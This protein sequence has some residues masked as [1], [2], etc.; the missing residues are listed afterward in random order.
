MIRF[1][2]VNLLLLLLFL[3][4]GGARAANTPPLMVTPG[5]LSVSSTGAATYTIPISVPPGTSGVIPQ[6]SLSYSS[7]NGDGFEGLGWTLNGLSAITRCPRT[8][9]QDGIHGSVNYDSNDRFCMDGQR[10]ISTGTTSTL[11]SSGTGTVYSTEIESFSRVI[12][13][14]SSGS[15]PAYFKVWTKAGQ[16]LEYGN[17]TDS[18]VL[19]VSTGTSTIPSG[20][21]REWL[22]DK[23]SDVVSNYFTVTYNCT[24]SGGSCTDADRTTN[25]E[26]Y[27]LHIDYTGNS[28]A[29]VSPYN[30]VKFLYSSRNDIASFYQAG[31]VT[32]RTVVLTDIKTYQG[33]NPVQDYQLGYRA[34]TSVLHSH[35]TS[36][37]Q[38]DG[39]GSCSPPCNNSPHCLNTMTFGWQGVT[40]TTVSI[41]TS[42]VTSNSDVVSGDWNGDG[43]TD[44][45]ILPTVQPTVCP[46]YPVYLGQ[47][48]FGFT[49]SSYVLTNGA[50]SSGAQYCLNYGLSN[51]V[52]AP[53]GTSDVIFTS[54]AYN[55]INPQ[56]SPHIFSSLL[57]SA[58]PINIAAWTGG[59]PGE[60]AG[61]FNG[62]GIIDFLATTASTYYIY[63]G[64]TSGTFTPDSGHSLI[65]G[66][67][68]TA[69]FDGDGCTDTSVQSSSPIAISYFCNP[70]V[71][72]SSGP[73][74]AGYTV[75]YGDFNGDGKT[76][77]L[78]TNSSSVPQLWLSTGTGFVNVADTLPSGTT[79]VAVGDWNGD[80]KA[81][82][83][84]SPSGGGD[85]QLY[86]STGTDF[87]PALSSSGDPVVLSGSS[88]G[89]ATIADWN[90][91][92][93]SDILIQFFGPGIGGID[94]YSL[95]TYVPE[96][97]TS[98]SSGIGSTTNIAYDRINK[99]SPFYQKCSNGTYSCGDPYPTETID[100]PQYVVS[101]ID[102]SNGL[103]TC[104]PAIS[105]ADCYRTTYTYM[106]AKKDLQGRGFLGFSQVAST[107]LQANIVQTTNYCTA[108][109]L[110]G[111]I[112]SATSVHSG[113]TLS[114]VANFY[115]GS[116]GCAAAATS[117]VNVVQQTESVVS[118]NDLSGAPLPTTTTTYTYDSY[119][120]PLTTNVSV[121]YSG[122][123]STKNTTNTYSNDTTNWFLGRLLT[124]SV[125]SIVGSSNLTR[126]SSFAYNPANGLL[127][128]ET[129]ESGVST[130]NGGSSSCELDTSYTYDVF[131]HRITTMVFGSGITPRTSYAFY[132]ALG[133]FKTSDANALGQYEF[134]TYNAGFGGPV[135]HT[136]PNNLTTNWTYDTF[137]RVTQEIRP[138][139]T[140]TNQSYAY[141]SGGCPGY[142]QFY[143]QSVIDGPGG[144]P[145]V[146]PASY[147]YYDML[148]RPI[149]NDSQGF[150][151][152]NIRVA[153]VYDGNLHVQ[154]TSR[155]Y[156]T[157]SASPAWTQFTYDD[158]GRVTEAVFPDTSQTTYSYNGLSTSV[159]NNLSQTTT[160]TK[161]AQGL[162]A[163]VT[164]AANH[165][166][167]YVYDA[168]GDL[169]T[170]TDPAE[171]TIT[172]TFDIR[173]NKV[174]SNDPDMGTWTYAY[175]VLSEL[176]SQTDAKS[177]VT[178]LTY[179]VLGRP[180]TRSEPSLY[181]AWTYGTSASNHNIGRV[182][183]A[184]A[185]PISACSTIVSNKTYLFDSLGRESQ[186]TLQTPTDYFGYSTTYNSSNGQVAS[187]TYPSGY[188]VS[189]AYNTTGFL[190]QLS[191]SMAPVWTLNAR[192]A[193][194][195]ITS[196][197]AGNNVTTT[198]SFNPQTGLIQ[199]QVAGGGAVANFSY[200]FDTIGN[201]TYRSDTNGS[202]AEFFCYDNLNRVTN[203]NFGSACTG[204]ATVG[205]D[206]LGNIT[207]KSDT[208]IYSYGGPKPHAV[209]SIT[210]TVDGLTNP[211]YSYDPNGN[212]TCVSSGGGCS[213]T[214]GRSV[215]LTSFNMVAS[216]DQG[217]NSL[218]MTYDDQHQR[219]QQT[220]TVSGTSTTTTVY[221]NDTASGAM[222]QRVTAAGTTPTDWGSFNWG[223]APW[224]GTTA[225]A[226]PTW[227]DYITIDG[228][229]VAQRN[230]QYPL[231][232]AWGLQ[233]WGSFNWG[234]PPGNN[235]G[236]FNWGAATWSGT[237]VNWSYFNLDHLG[238]V[239]VIADQGGNVVQRLSYDAWG[240]PRSPNGSTLSCG[241]ITSS[242]TRG[243]TNQEEMPTQCM[244][245]LN[246]RLYD[247]SIG[248]FMAPDSV[249]QDAFNGQSFNRYAY[250][251][252]NPLSFT[253]PTGMDAEDD[254]N[255]FK[256]A[257]AT[258]ACDVT[259]CND[260]GNIPSQGEPDQETQLTQV[261][262]SASLDAQIIASINQSQQMAENGSDVSANVGAAAQVVGTNT[263][264]AQFARGLMAVGGSTGYVDENGSGPIQ[265]TVTQ[266]TSPIVS[267]WQGNWGTNGGLI[268][269]AGGYDI[270]SHHYDFSVPLC[271]GCSTQQAFDVV[272]SFSAPGAG[273]AQ[274]GTHK[275]TLAG[276]NGHNQIIQT[277]DPDALTI[278][279]TTLPGHVFYPGTVQLSVTQDQA[280]VVSLHVVGQGT[281]AYSTDNQIFG[282]AI[283]SAL[284]LA[285][286]GALNPDLGVRN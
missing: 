171:N 132:D 43:L 114:S 279:N 25:G 96:L 284:G 106:G 16:I 265:V 39:S 45:G 236:S 275:V 48:S 19:V 61:D 108:F 89:T 13:C 1:A 91:D 248:K 199:S 153:T 244:V 264:S 205:Y 245:N 163:T 97:M 190:T 101:E 252:N 79:I 176:V 118:G 111:L 250:T 225:N 113:T 63:L 240:K 21:I 272:R 283:F 10:L 152:S 103:G 128:Q 226:L 12:S 280:G 150:D 20:T 112:S 229:I 267:T 194:L 139:G 115:N 204:G 51:T 122:S 266:G 58:G 26:A 11:C 129:I 172:N 270:G 15:G 213:G 155:P 149:A 94:D 251:N 177:Q 31:G 3:S 99:N 216:M 253:D 263:S 167:S 81:D 258:G 260:A 27:P 75:T 6:L 209:S 23:V 161:N 84:I 124:T 185:C 110:T 273:Y 44:V 197:T 183:Q 7:Q 77:I 78:L 88:G 69:D 192:D 71:A 242:T 239:S 29:G 138:D 285:A 28:N 49:S 198:Q 24:A 158:L 243:Y 117:G 214:I 189:R 30:S 5:Q 93:A 222:S 203:Y 249:V 157:S 274:N 62:D 166:T 241:T 64:S 2:T 123:T 277:V 100:G 262:S 156:F 247:A 35:L 196:Q 170:V 187:I 154:E 237:V 164:D 232:S 278:T 32:K 257:A 131:G 233:K 135:S 36:L 211:N 282:P 181:S 224:G 67:Y 126:Q 268:Q 271:L 52:L 134:W 140:Q 116:L 83:L 38:C 145:Q 179:D 33:T 276:N 210:G 159:T 34:G 120:N 202:Y 169:L 54:N 41:A 119:N 186:Y 22:V 174:A 220:N 74:A 72:T 136:G 17:T 219:L 46:P 143:S 188:T 206:A 195:H 147:A 228:Q 92:G 65:P 142:G 70:A 14:G 107:N 82:I 207:S 218:S 68:A 259:S 193:E 231:A 86:L 104:N 227:T 165:N 55:S 109:P 200:Q 223:N 238:S 168:F 215:N 18:A 73:A 160:T 130:C 246:A 137:G 47:A 201:L 208:G 80:G 255:A 53:D 261:I 95:I 144:S 148:S 102:A 254:I 175:N 180:L 90:N 221:L 141:C 76:D 162:N 184:E 85:Y 235:W 151:G 173:G 121:T 8:I 234:T 56:P 182:V 57:T 40:Y 230:V 281:G 87:T 191:D 60:F 212:L 127:T 125:N 217:T 133:Q 286:Y 98:V 59:P 269:V 42:G 37:T 66:I 105:Y 9:A 50:A 146:G 256:Y 178:S 4:G